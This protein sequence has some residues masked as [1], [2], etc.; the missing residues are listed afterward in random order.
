[1]TSYDGKPLPTALLPT[2]NL[3]V[4][5]RRKTE[6]RSDD[7]KP[8]PTAFL[9]I[10][11]LKVERRRKTEVRSDVGKPLPTAFLLI[12]NFKIDRSQ[13]TEDRRRVKALRQASRQAGTTAQPKKTAVHQVK[14]HNHLI[15][16][17]QI[18]T[19]T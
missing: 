2:A 17:K 6:D 18:N 3:K 4:E 15:S 12:A 1:V 8:L 9:L 14:K 5:R 13:K 16:C 11:N 10:A 7:G 19:F